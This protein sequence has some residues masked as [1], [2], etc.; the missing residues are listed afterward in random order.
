M[1]SWRHAIRGASDGLL[2]PRSDG[3]WEFRPFGILGVS[4]LLREPS[5]YRTAKKML[6]ALHIA[7]GVMAVLVS[8]MLV[9]V[10]LGVI[11]Q[12]YFA[13]T[14]MVVALSGIAFLFFWVRSLSTFVS[15]AEV[16]RSE[17]PSV[18]S[19]DAN[20]THVHMKRRVE[21]LLLGLLCLAAIPVILFPDMPDGALLIWGGACVLSALLRLAMATADYLRGRI[22]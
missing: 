11:G 15:S 21:K 3:T 19:K 12:L 1:I 2:R 7:L 5:A 9:L 6:A 18:A 16:V 17:S 20:N 22:E 10:F 14:S 4:Y 8:V 13:V